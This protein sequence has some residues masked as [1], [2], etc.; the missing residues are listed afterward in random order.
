MEWS[1]GIHG[2]AIKKK[3]KKTSPNWKAKTRFDSALSRFARNYERVTI[4]RWNDVFFLYSPLHPLSLSSTFSFLPFVSF[5]LIY[6]SRSREDEARIFVR[7]KASVS[8]RSSDDAPGDWHLQT[9][10]KP[11]TVLQLTRDSIAGMVI[12]I[13][14]SSSDSRWFFFFLFY[15][16]SASNWTEFLICL[17]AGCPDHGRRGGPTLFAMRGFVFGI[18][19]AHVEVRNNRS[20]FLLNLGSYAVNR[21][22]SFP[23]PRR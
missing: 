20:K 3:R 17:I 14:L 7:R 5:F 4:A 12:P 22:N 16:I 9:W 2:R 13:H 10:S 11:F 23:F 6:I 1:A 19:T 8:S 21:V 18:L 15:N